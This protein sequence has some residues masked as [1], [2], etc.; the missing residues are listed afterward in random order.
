MV[1][2]KGEATEV[3]VVRWVNKMWFNHTY[4]LKQGGGPDICS[5]VDG[6]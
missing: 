6:P 1:S 5:I 2:R 3:S 4:S